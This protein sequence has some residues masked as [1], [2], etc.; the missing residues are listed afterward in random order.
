M[1]AR[2]LLA[3]SALALAFGC[4]DEKLPTAPSELT[5]PTDPSAIISDGAHNGGNPDFFFLPPMVPLP[6][7]NA[8][9]ELGK[10][11]NT[12]KNSLKIDICELNPEPGNGLPKAA[13]GCARGIKTF[14]PGSVNVV[15]LP[16]R[17]NGWWNFFGLPP[18]G[19]YYALWDTRQSNLNVS[20]YYRIKVYIAGPPDVLLGIADVDPMA[21]L[22][23]WK[24]TLT[25]EV[26]QLVDNVLLPVV[27][28]VEKGGGPALC[29]GST[30]C[31]SATI[32]NDNPNGDV[33]VLQTPG[34]NGPIAGA[35]FP[36]GWLPVGPGLP[37]SVVVTISSVNT[38]VNNVAAGTQQFPCH[39][40][41][42]LQQFN[43]C[44]KFTTTPALT[45]AAEGGHQFARN[46]TVVACYVLHDT[47]DPR[48]PFAQL[49]SSGPNEPAHPLVSVSDASVLTVETEHDCGSN[50]FTIIGSNNSR[51]NP[52]VQLASAGWQKLKGGMGRLVGIKTAYAVDLGLGGFT[53]DFSNVGPA[54]TA[55]IQRYTNTDLTLGPGAT[56]TSTARI[57]GTQA[58]NGGTLTTGI[59]GLPVTF[60]VAEGNGTLRL[61]GS[62]AP[63]AGQVTSI[64]NTDAIN[65]ESPVSGGGF[66]PV[67]WTMPTAPGTYTLTATGQATGGPVTFTATVAAA[68][69]PII[70]ASSL[71]NGFGPSDL[72]SIQIGVNGVDTRVAQIHGLAGE[73]LTITDIASFNG[74]GLVGVSFSELYFIEPQSGL[75]TTAGLIGRSDVNG[76][77]A[78]AN[79]ELYASTQGGLLLRRDFELG[80]VSQGSLGEGLSSDGDLAFAPNGTLY[81][82]LRTSGGVSV[83]ASIDVSTGAATVLSPTSGLG[84][85]NVWGLAFVGSNL[86]GL[87]TEPLGAGPPGRLIQIDPSTGVATSIRSLT[88]GA[89]G[90]A[91]NR[92]R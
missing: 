63:P 64:T 4:R 68:P 41:L 49:W 84:F 16:L 83:L 8:N 74:G 73:P 15:N 17:Q 28:R 32:T 21:N 66:A 60:T 71:V 2:R 34:N 79:G 33:Q 62:E 80:W 24:Y 19:F 88:F 89:G 38:G 48:G 56:T 13:T 47:D 59:G 3:L 30:I 10:F 87:T 67:N 12:L 11:N 9:F 31:G 36:D 5:P 7:H 29:G 76:L 37:T 69:L 90:A 20:K 53:L 70:F 18:D 39:A 14:G 1:K 25:G 61:I 51:A 82:T 26:I 45:G 40:N 65:P 91:F 50:V 85:S 58:H 6:L 27:F 92:V 22:F 75:A 78:N 57:V 86:Y 54:L 42:P 81:G 46:V 52:L 23:Q 43:G 77:A 44:F 35:V 72:Y 55:Q